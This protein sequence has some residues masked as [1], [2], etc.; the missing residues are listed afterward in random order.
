MR[1]DEWVNYVR[2]VGGVDTDGVLGKQCMDLYN[3]Y[4][5]KVLNQENVGADC[6]KNILNNPNIYKVVDVIEN[7]PDFIVQKGDIVVFRNM[8]VWGHVVVALGPADLYGYKCIE[9]NWRNQCELSEVWHD[10]IYGNPVFLRPKDQSNIRDEFKAYNVIVTA[11]VLNVRE[12]PGI[13]YNIK[14][15]TQLTQNAQEQVKEKC[16]Y[17]ANGLVEGVE[18]TIL[19][20]VNNWGRIPSGWICLDY[21]KKV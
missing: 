5:N 7:Y 15:Y 21:T 17:C 2:S 19:E 9:Q 13:N 18:A 10:Y 8:G 16:G 3:S 14:K 6:A 4:V 11:D 20:V 12:G 1:F